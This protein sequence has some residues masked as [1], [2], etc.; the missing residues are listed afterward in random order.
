MY[1][2]CSHTFLA[3]DLTMKTSVNSLILMLDHE[4]LS[5]QNKFLIWGEGKLIYSILTISGVG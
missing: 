4:M 3:F 5:R 2:Y 1:D